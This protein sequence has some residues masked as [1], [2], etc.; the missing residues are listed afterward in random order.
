MSIKRA[1]EI[2]KIISN[3]ATLWSKHQEQRLGQLLENYVF[4]SV[5]TKQG[6]RTALTFFQEDSDT[7]KTLQSLNVKEETEGKKQ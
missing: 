4:P 5:Q 3:L 7:L 2:G 1:E 6:G